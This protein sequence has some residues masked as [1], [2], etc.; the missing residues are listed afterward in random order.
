MADF[1]RTVAYRAIYGAVHNAL[2][3][4][5]SWRVPQDFARSVAKRAS[6]TLAAHIGP[7]ALASS[8]RSDKG[9]GRCH[10]AP[11][12]GAGARFRGR[13]LSH[14]LRASSPGASSA[15]QRRLLT[16]CHQLLS[17]YVS[18]AKRTGDLDRAA[19]L[20]AGLRTIQDE[21]NR[22]LAGG[23]RKGIEEA[24]SPSKDKAASP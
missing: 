19:R 2:D 3:G 18:E 23:G 16:I 15:L 22:H 4:H 7:S 20:I 21:I 5:P 14:A 8:A 1:S 10:D 17:T 12:R 13:L 9:L 24:R 11:A 6:G